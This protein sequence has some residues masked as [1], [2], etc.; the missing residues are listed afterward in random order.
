MS[1]LFVVVFC[2][3]GVWTPA[4]AQTSDGGF[5]AELSTT[6]AASAR[7]MHATIRRNEHYGNIIVYMRLKGRVPPSTARGSRPDD[8]PPGGHLSRHS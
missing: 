8:E 5:D 1:R 2:L 7:A 3:A 6:L 4:L